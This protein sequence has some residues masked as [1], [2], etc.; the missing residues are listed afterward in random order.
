MEKSGEKKDTRPDMFKVV[1]PAL[2]AWVRHQRGVGNDVS[3]EDLLDEYQD[4]VE[5]EL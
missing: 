3:G 4:T 2:T 5:S 1:H